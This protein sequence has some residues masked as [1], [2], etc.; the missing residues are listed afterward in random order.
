MKNIKK[1]SIQ[2]LFFNNKFALIFS[3]VV[4]FFVWA[5]VVI[6]LSPND[7]RIVENVKVSV[8]NNTAEEMELKLFGFDEGMTVDVSV[9]GK[10]YAISTSALT[11]DDISVVAKGGYVDSA[12][13]YTLNISATPKDPGAGFD[14]IGISKETISVFYDTY[15]TEDFNVEAELTA[16]EIVPEGYLSD[17]PISSLATVS[18]SGPATEINKIERVVAYATLD[19]PVTET[20]NIT[21]DVVALTANKSTLNYITFNSNI[22][23]CTV[24]VPVYMK[25]EI[26]LGVKYLNAPEAY[27]G[28][29]PKVTITPATLNIAAAKSVL[30]ELKVL[31][32][33]SLDFNRL[34]AADNK[35]TFETD[36]ID[37]VKVL[38][39]VKTIVVNVDFSALTSKRLSIPAN[40]ITCLN[41][42]EG[43]TAKPQGLASV[44]VVGPEAS[45]AAL[46][47]A[48]IN[49][50]VDL[51]SIGETEGVAMVNADVSVRNHGDCWIYGKYK[52]SVELTK[53]G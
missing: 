2:R 40:G 44:A 30:D 22:T 39:S 1:F 14:V 32:I 7:T 9:T 26:S 46:T 37:E 51:S 36:D 50:R 34:A 47:E 49:V 18:I 6:T 35:L 5:S 45:L 16:E 31:Y 48:D 12:G 25:K 19:K 24:T 42:A 33:G 23:S 15:K 8:Q 10:R 21:A 28:S 17:D 4:A 38:D 43:F 29:S 41:V 53:Q 3:V 52:V 27:A 11:A 20:V 13:A